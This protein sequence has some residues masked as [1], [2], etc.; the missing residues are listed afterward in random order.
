MTTSQAA[1]RPLVGIDWG[2]TNRRAYVLDADGGLLKRHADEKGLL[3]VDGKFEEAL[4][5]LLRRLELE[6]ADV[7]L[8]GMVGSRNGW[9]EVPYLTADTPLAGLAGAMVEVETRLPDTRCRIVPGYRY[10]E[11]G[12]PDVMRGE[13]IQI[14]GAL[15]LGAAQGWFALPGTHSKWVRVEAGAIKEMATFMTGELFS[16]LS[17][18][19]TLAALMEKQDPVPAAFEAGLQAAGRGGFTHMAFVCRALVVTDAMP[20]GHAWSYLSGLLI[21]SELHEI[22]RRTG[23]QALSE[24]QIIGSPALVERYADAFRLF[25]IPCRTWLPADVYVAAL[26]TLAGIHDNQR[27]D[28]AHT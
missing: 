2:T 22:K 24:V 15:Q 23:G 27:K 4:A 5:E 10:L 1:T 26:R 9:R 19:G 13:E 8:S 18:H 12:M 17:W 20:A 3:A 16:L 7:I 6:H 25:E 14:L 21:G 11:N 28:H